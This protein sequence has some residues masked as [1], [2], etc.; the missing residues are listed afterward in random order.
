MSKKEQ[1]HIK[2]EEQIEDVNFDSL[3]ETEAEKI[4]EKSSKKSKK[5]SKKMTEAEKLV[6]MEEKCE[7]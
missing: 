7:E 3:E 1:Q 2:E 4:E 5:K 6:E